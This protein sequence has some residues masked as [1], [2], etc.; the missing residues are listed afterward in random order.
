MI[1]GL[2]VDGYAVTFERVQRCGVGA[3]WANVVTHDHHDGH[4]HDDHDH[5]DHDHDIT[6]STSTTDTWP[7]DRYARSTNCSTGPTSPIVCAARARAVFERLAAVEGAIHGIDPADVELHEVGALD[8]IIDVV[9]VCAA[10]ESLGIAEIRCSPIALGSG[11]VRSAHGLIPNPA[12]ATLALLRDAGAPTVGLATTLE[13]TTPTG[14][15]LMTTLAQGFG[16]APP[17]TIEAVGYGAGTA[18]P[19]ERANVVQVVIGTSTANDDDVDRAPRWSCSRPTS[20]TRPARSSPTRSSA[21]LAAGA[22]DAW[23]TPIVMKKGRP[24]HTVSVLCDPTDAGESARRHRRTRPARSACGPRRS[25]AGRNGARWQPSTSTVTRS[26][27]RSPSTASRSS[28]T[29]RHA[30]QLRWAGRSPRSSPVPS[31]QGDHSSA[32]SGRRGRRGERGVDPGPELVGGALAALPGEDRA[33]AVDASPGTGTRC[34][35]TRSSA[36]E[37]SLSAIVGQRPALVD[38]PFRRRIVR[39]VGCHRRADPDDVEVGGYAAGV[40]QA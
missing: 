15:A 40:V 20:T 9:G 34:R 14:A 13:V 28:S 35:R 23:L 11:T 6:T 25:P 10:L 37:F 36:S 39:P 1:A 32:E 3:T 17:M 12:P 29:T 5:D 26:A 19:P 16:A 2:G 24:A 30:L 33:V 4:H 18:D 22:H 8:S 21:L 31:R 38:D 7:T 27:S